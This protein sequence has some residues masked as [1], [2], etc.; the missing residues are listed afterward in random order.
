MNALHPQTMTMNPELTTQ[1]T[2]LGL[3]AAAAELD[4]FVAR[5]AKSKWSPRQLLE[6][7]ARR[8]TSDKAARQLE[9]R[10]RTARSFIP[11]ALQTAGRF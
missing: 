8:E 7:L 11:W 9:S 4:D 3:R 10:L 5:A 1:L 6:E 2:R